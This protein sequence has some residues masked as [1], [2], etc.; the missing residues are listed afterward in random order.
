MIL[1]DDLNALATL[2]GTDKWNRHWYTRHYQ[3]HF[4]PV[5]MERL[6]ILEI[7]IGGEEDP[8]AGG[9]SLRMWRDFFPH[10]SVFGLDIHKKN[11]T[12]EERI[13]V[14]Q[15][16]QTNGDDLQ[17]VIDAAG[18]FD[19]IIDDGSHINEHVIESFHFLFPRMS[20]RGLYVIEDTQTSY[21]DRYYGGSLYLN[22]L[23]T[24]MGFMKRLVDGLNYE[25]YPG[26]RDVFVSDY[27]NEHIT[28]MHFYHN[29][30]FLYKGINRENSMGPSS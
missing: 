1:H 18:S 6:N 2:Y 12:D 7:G 13:T 19:I 15:G 22:S 25:E 14:F 17:R 9:A 16:D 27:T 23:H 8:D 20:E 30:V 10:S 5:R 29:L 21:W 26:N 28:S 11:I 24:T 4:G 3:N